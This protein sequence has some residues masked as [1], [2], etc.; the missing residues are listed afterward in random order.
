MLNLPDRR[1]KTR[2][3]RWWAMGG[4]P[5]ELA[6]NSWI[7]LLSIEY[8]SSWPVVILAWPI[9][10]AGYFL[11]EN[12]GL[13]NQGWKRSSQTPVIIVS[14]YKVAVEPINGRKFYRL[15]R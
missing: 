4:T 10:A 13:D 6:L 15:R 2:Q 9:S 3:I 11:E 5:G 14:E 1:E 12:S 8:V 7:E